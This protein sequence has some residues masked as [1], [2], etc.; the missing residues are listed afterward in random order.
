MCI[1]CVYRWYGGDSVVDRWLPQVAKE[2]RARGSG[3]RQ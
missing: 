2:S 3:E 1:L